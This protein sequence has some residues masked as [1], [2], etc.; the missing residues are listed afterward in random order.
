MLTLSNKIPCTGQSPNSQVV[1]SL[2]PE[3]ISKETGRI[4]V[5]PNLQL[6]S[7]AG[8]FPHIFAVGD[9]AE[10]GG[11]KMARAGYF[12][13]DVVANNI[14]GLIENRAPLRVY[15]PNRMVEGSLKLSLGRVSRP[16]PLL[17][18]CTDF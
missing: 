11:P 9:V 14:V 15:K 10:T 4:L 2:S 8:Y 12:Q 6:Q 18:T 13:A 17:S 7:T 3:S 5:K 1:S 16:C